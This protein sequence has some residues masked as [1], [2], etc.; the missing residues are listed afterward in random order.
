[1]ITAECHQ[2][3]SDR[4]HLPPACLLPALLWRDERAVQPFL[5][6]RL[7]PLWRLLPPWAQ[8]DDMG[9]FMCVSRN[10]VTCNFHEG[11]PSI[12]LLLVCLSPGPSCS[13]HQRMYHREHN[14]PDS[15]M[16]FVDELC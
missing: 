2:L 13:L 1:M 3:P 5:P 11:F 15:V 4:S 6:Q 9:L 10:N 16:L 14:E 7:P 8:K 12:P